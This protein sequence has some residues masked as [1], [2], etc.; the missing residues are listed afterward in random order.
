MAGQ[1]ENL[2]A[3]ERLKQLRGLELVTERLERL[4]KLQKEQLQPNP[5]RTD[6]ATAKKNKNEV[7]RLLPPPKSPAKGVNLHIALKGSPG[8]GKTESAKLI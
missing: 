2:P 8:T 5:E 6:L 4:I 7:N 3:L 1:L